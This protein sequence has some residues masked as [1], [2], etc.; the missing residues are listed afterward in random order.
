M[1]MRADINFLFEMGTLRHVRRTWNQFGGLSMAN[2]AEHTF[3]VA[4]LAWLIAEREGVDTN[5]VLKMAIVHDMTEIRT[6]DVNMVSRLYAVRKE[7]EAIND[8]TEEVAMQD[9]MRALWRECEERKTKAAK[10]VKD[11][12]NLDIELE[13]MESMARGE[14]FSRALQKKREAIRDKLF[15]KTAKQLFD[16][17]RVADPNEWVLEGKNRFTHGDWKKK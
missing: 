16:E 12:D 6:G 9:E 5:Q 13:L 2:D 15:T 10:I 7:E 17:I 14:V 8:Q 1:N 11:A 4:V 3:R